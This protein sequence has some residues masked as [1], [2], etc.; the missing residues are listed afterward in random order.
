MDGKVTFG[1]HEPKGPTLAEIAKHKKERRRRA[2]SD[3]AAKLM[4]STENNDKSKDTKALSEKEIMELKHRIRKD[5]EQC[6]SYAEKIYPQEHL[7]KYAKIYA[8]AAI[9]M[10]ESF[11]EANKLQENYN[12]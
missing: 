1:P 5:L 2:K 10:K 9:S 11:Q 7:N 8:E 6:P 4:N 3:I 12:A